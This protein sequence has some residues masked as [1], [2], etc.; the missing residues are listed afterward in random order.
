MAG[1]ATAA[2][3]DKRRVTFR[4]H[5]GKNRMDP[6]RADDVNALGRLLARYVQSRVDGG[7]GMRNLTLVVCLVAV[8]LGGISGC[9]SASEGSTAENVTMEG[10][11][12]E[13]VDTPENGGITMYFGTN[14]PMT[15]ANFNA[16]NVQIF[17]PSQIGSPQNIAPIVCAGYSLNG[18]IG[19]AKIDGHVVTPTGAFASFSGQLSANGQAISDGK[20]SGQSCTIASTATIK[21]TLQ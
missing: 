13:Y 17:Q 4:R 6:I 20:Y 11:Q 1:W 21:G 15:N 19:G 8:L 12:W 10:G 16:S 7:I 5:P 2:G 3:I 14:L 18:V 9:G